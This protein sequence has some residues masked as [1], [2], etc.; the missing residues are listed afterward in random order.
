LR[1]QSRTH[2]G[3]KNRTRRRSMTRIVHNVIGSRRRTIGVPHRDER[4][5]PIGQ[6]Q[7]S[8]ARLRSKAR[9]C[10]LSDELPGPP[11]GVK[12]RTRSERGA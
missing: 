2:R 5:S 7:L 1:S 6:D 11:S 9:P 12:G 3:H 8:S 4:T 10:S